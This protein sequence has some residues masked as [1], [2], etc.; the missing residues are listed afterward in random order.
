[1]KGIGPKTA[2]ALLNH[3]NSL[4][5]LYSQVD[6]MI[7]TPEEIEEEILMAK[8]KPKRKSKSKLLELESELELDSSIGGETETEVAVDGS[9]SLPLLSTDSSSSSSSSSSSTREM[10]QKF[11][12]ELTA[13]LSN[14]QASAGT[15]LKKLQT[16]NHAEVLLFKRLVT[17][18]DDV[19]IDDLH[20]F[21][22]DPVTASTSVSV[23]VSGPAVDEEFKI[24]GEA[25]KKKRETKAKAKA[26]AQAK[27]IVTSEVEEISKSDENNDNTPE[28][29]IFTP[30][31]FPEIING[32]TQDLDSRLSR[33][34]SSHF[35]YSGE[36]DGA[37]QVLT[38]MSAS[39]I[40]PLS[41]LRQQYHKLERTLGSL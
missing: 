18:R 20:G 28:S 16:S 34:S 12:V 13:A 31:L 5:N 6:M 10:K 29:V 4:G 40:T 38:G 41:L 8:A 39:F 37:E 17:L 14:V 1:M 15:T 19:H 24:V 27:E 3:F 7:S 21:L 33:V 32:E 9:L 2:C 11:L 22:P 23:S 30:I 26:Q 36:R 35:L 25:I